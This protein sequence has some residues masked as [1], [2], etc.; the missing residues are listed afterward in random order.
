[1][2]DARAKA[3]RAAEI[4]SEKKAEGLA[5]LDVRTLASY[6]DYFLICHGRSDRQVQAIAEAILTAFKAEGVSPLAVEGVEAGQWVLMDYADIVVHVFYEPV[7]SYYDL[8]GLWADAPRV[9]L[10]AALEPAAAPP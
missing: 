7:R 4:A 3:I 8:D 6:T 2:I 9:R 5:V 10:P 1:M